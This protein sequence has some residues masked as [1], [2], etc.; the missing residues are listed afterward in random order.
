MKKIIALI[1]VLLVLLS[2]SILARLPIQ[3]APD[4]SKQQN[5]EGLTQAT[6]M[7]NQ[8]M[9]FYGYY[10]AI[11]SGNVG[12]IIFQQ[13]MS[14][15]MKDADPQ[16]KTTITFLQTLKQILP[17]GVKGS[18]PSQQAQI[19]AQQKQKEISKHKYG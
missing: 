16:T 1:L 14:I 5:K 2:I 11:V 8:Y 15:A 9:Q 17:K 7:L 6:N 19:A 13:F 12:G 18:P 4:A 3:G 10:Q